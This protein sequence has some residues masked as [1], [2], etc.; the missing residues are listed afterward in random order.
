[1]GTGAFYQANP[2]GFCTVDL[3]EW[4]ALKAKYEKPVFNWIG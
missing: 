1:M 4:K 3:K 2:Q